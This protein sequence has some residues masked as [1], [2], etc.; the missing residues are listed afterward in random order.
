MKV[1][2]NEGS[3]TVCTAT[4]DDSGNWSCTPAA[5]LTSGKQTITATATDPTG[6]TSGASPS[7]SFDAS[8]LPPGVAVVG[9]VLGT[10]NSNYGMS[11]NTAAYDGPTTAGDVDGLSAATSTDNNIYFQVDKSV[12]YE[13]DYT[14]TFKIQYYDSGTGSFQVQYDDGSS[15]PYLA[16]TPNI[17][18]TN[19]DT[20]KT[21]TVTGSNAYF[22]GLQNGSADFRL[23]NGN[24]Q[25]T[26]HAVEVTIS[27]D[28]VANVVDYPPAVAIS[29]PAAGATVSTTPTISGT[30]E[31]DAAITVSAGGA[32]VCTATADDTGAWSCIPSTAL[33]DGSTTL[34]ATAIDVLAGQVNS[35]AVQI[36]VQG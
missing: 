30:S 32:P 17:Q 25:V 13:G 18:L 10:T 22:G 36:T 14:V 15:N 21:A 4:A 23:R 20:W 33:S 11:Q 35:S 19:T 34:T 29:S 12:A 1:T 9:T 8:N 5:G 6:F 24:G 16:A 7:V 28:G 26:V 3:T 2:V 27:G 31:P